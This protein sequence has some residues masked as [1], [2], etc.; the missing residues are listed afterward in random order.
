MLSTGLKTSLLHVD[1]VLIKKGATPAG[2][3]AL[4]QKPAD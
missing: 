2:S 3:L 1:S 4:D